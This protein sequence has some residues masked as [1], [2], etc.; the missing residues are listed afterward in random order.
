[1]DR[2]LFTELAFALSVVCLASAC[3]GS[4]APAVEDATALDKMTVAFK[5][6]HSRREIER[7]TT[8]V[9]RLYSLELT[10]Q[11]YVE[12][13]DMLVFLR[14]D[15]EPHTEFDLMRCMIPLG[16]GMGDV[17]LSLKEAA[18]LCATQIKT[19]MSG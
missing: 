1:M 12:L 7:E 3:D 5:G 11:N 13:G 2:K 4:S 15:L 14:K 9:L 19:G 6:D 18:A 10:E 17:R 8:T 16:R